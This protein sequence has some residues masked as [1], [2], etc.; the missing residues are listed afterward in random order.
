[1]QFH[2]EESETL[3]SDFFL[4]QLSGFKLLFSGCGKRN[5][6]SFF[7]PLAPDNIQYLRLWYPARSARQSRFLTHDTGLLGLINTG[8][9]FRCTPAHPAEYFFRL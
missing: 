9:H 1:M 6:A 2:G 8:E 4:C 3:R 7:R 5:L